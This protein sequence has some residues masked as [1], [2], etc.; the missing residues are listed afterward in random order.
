[1]SKVLLQTTTL[2][3]KKRPKSFLGTL[4]NVKLGIVCIY[5]IFEKN[6]LCALIEPPDNMSRSFMFYDKLKIYQ[7]YNLIRGRACIVT[8]YVP[9]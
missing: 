1:M 7:C 2:R 3:H 5:L 9:Y 6:G 4:S 8:L